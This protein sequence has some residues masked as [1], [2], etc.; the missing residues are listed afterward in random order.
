[1]PVFPIEG[2]LTRVMNFV[3]VGGSVPPY[4]MQ[5]IETSSPGLLGQSGGPMFDQEGTVWAIQSETA[6]LPLGFDAVVT[7]QF[8][9]VGRGAHVSTVLGLFDEHGIAYKKSDY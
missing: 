3:D 4:P 1:L 2:I 6:H 9:N 7:P 5:K 8:L